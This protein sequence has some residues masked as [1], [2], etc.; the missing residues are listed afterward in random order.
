MNTSQRIK[1][2]NNFL[3]INKYLE[4]GVHFGDTFNNLELP[5]KVAVDP[6]FQFDYKNLENSSC[7]FYSTTSDD[8]FTNHSDQDIFDLIFLDGLHEFPQTLRDFNSAIKHSNKRTLIILDDVY[9]NDVFSSLSLITNPHNLRKRN[10]PENNDLSWHGDV[11]KTIFFIHDFFPTY[12]YCTIDWG[13]GN[14]QA[15]I[16]QKDR[17]NFKPRFNDLEKISRLTYFDLLENIDILNLM[18]EDS[19]IDYY[20]NYLAP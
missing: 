11:F 17:V 5:Y 16:F 2:I 14:P 1:K 18:S 19:A 12:T 20:Q 4:I 7:K 3:N 8:Y 10:N 13:Y 9:P 15:L 6:Y